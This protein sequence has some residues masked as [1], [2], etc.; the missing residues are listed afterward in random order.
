M[1]HWEALLADLVTDWQG[2]A[3]R[4]D[5]VAKL[6]LL[7]A[8]AQRHSLTWTNPQM[9]ALSL[10]FHDIRPQRSL[11]RRL[12]T[13]QLITEHDIVTAMHSPPEDTRAY[14]RG[15]CLRRWPDDIVSVNWDSLV[16]DVGQKALQRVP[17]L[18]PLRGTKK[19]VGALFD[20]VT[21][22]AEL[23]VALSR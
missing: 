20:T 14:F 16:F 18:D 15:I 13:Q 22:P 8:Y 23:V 9:Q 3:D 2:T 21:S 7:S 11:F 1:G 10:Q 12:T 5:W 19:L 6:Q 4:I 17:T